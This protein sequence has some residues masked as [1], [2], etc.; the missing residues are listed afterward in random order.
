MHPIFYLLLAALSLYIFGIAIHKIIIN[1]TNKTIITTS[2]IRS[3]QIQ[4]PAPISNIKDV[5]FQPTNLTTLTVDNNTHSFNM[6][7]FPLTGLFK[8]IEF[9]FDKNESNIS[10]DSFIGIQILNSLE[11]APLYT[12]RTTA[13]NLTNPYNFETNG[14]L[15]VFKGQYI[16]ILLSGASIK[17]FNPSIKVTID[18]TSQ[19][20]YYPEPTL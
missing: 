2:D 6:G 10:P 5:T 8:N 13:L 1:T 18:E 16:N 15:T 3:N 7:M 9:S 12:L 20:T 14:D 19:T 4:P 11:E 17:I